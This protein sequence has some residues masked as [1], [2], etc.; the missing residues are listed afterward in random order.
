MLIYANY[1]KTAQP[2]SFFLNQ[3]M[4]IWYSDNYKK[5][6]ENLSGGDVLQLPTS[7]VFWKTY[8][9]GSGVCLGVEMSL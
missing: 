7:Q 4:R 1:M 6:G 9:T 8:T 3:K 2:I 5:E